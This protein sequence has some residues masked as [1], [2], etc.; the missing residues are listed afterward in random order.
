MQ[1][2]LRRASRRVVDPGGGYLGGNMVMLFL[3]LV[4]IIRDTIL[5]NSVPAIIHEA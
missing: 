4:T 5:L 3:Q 1:W 2:N